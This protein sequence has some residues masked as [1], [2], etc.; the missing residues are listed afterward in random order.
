[1]VEFGS[2]LIRPSYHRLAT[3]GL[4]WP[5]ALGIAALITVAVLTILAALQAWV[6]RDTRRLLQEFGY[7]CKQCGQSPWYTF[8][9]QVIAEGRCPSCHARLPQ[10]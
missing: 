4:L 5:P 8:A 3:V 10:E 7:H 9:D 2:Q 1:M 6:L